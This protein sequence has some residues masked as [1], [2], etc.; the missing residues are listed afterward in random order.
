MEQPVPPLFH[1]GPDLT[2]APPSLLAK[3]EAYYPPE[4]TS[5][6][7]VLV[8]L[9]GRSDLHAAAGEALQKPP[10]QGH[11]INY[12]GIPDARGAARLFGAP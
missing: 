1:G 5:P 4:V 9:L 3:M 6:P 7:L 2:V 11:Q 8:A 10:D 12:I